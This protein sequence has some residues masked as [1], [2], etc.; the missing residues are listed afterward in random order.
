[1]NIIIKLEQRDFERNKEDVC[2]VRCVKSA[3]G[4]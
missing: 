1:M 4:G 3:D 2:P